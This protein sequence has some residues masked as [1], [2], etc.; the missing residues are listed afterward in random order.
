MDA[1][2]DLSITWSDADDGTNGGGGMNVS[3]ESGIGE[4]PGLDKRFK[5]VL[6][7]LLTLPNNTSTTQSQS[8]LWSKSQPIAVP[9]LLPDEQS[10]VLQW[11][12][13]DTHKPLRNECLHELFEKQAKENPNAIALYDNECTMSMTYRQLDCLSDAL[14]LKLQTLG[15]KT[16]MFVGLLMSKKTFDLCVGVLGILKS[17][18]AYV[19]MDPVQFPLE[20]VRFMVNDTGMNIMV[21]VKAHG[22]YVGGLDKCD[23]LRHV[24]YIDEALS[25]GDDGDD[26]AGIAS[27]HDD[28]TVSTLHRGLSSPEDYAYMIYTSGTTGMPKGEFE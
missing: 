12:Q 23:G 25:M 15:A 13:G 6:N 21:T 17:G 28:D 1:K 26:D 19:P 5:Q 10:K 24:V 27:R 3:F 16:N 9:L 18:A 4:W 14:A 2:F 11:G 8:Q 7:G 20:R 22:E